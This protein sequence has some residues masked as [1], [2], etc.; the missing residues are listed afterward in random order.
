MAYKKNGGKCMKRMTVTVTIDRPLGSYH[1]KHKNLFYPVNYGYVKDVVGGDGEEQDAYVL[2]VD[3]P[4]SKFTGKIIAIIH[5]KND[6][7]DKWVVAPENVSFS[8]EE[9]EQAV[10]FQEKY[11]E[12]E[13]LM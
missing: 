3:V 6:V 9:I 8:K 2:G 4:I 7:E 5:R 1:P 10:K 11:F 13:I 12:Y